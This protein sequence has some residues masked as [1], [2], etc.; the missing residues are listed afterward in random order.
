MDDFGP[1]TREILQIQI[2]PDATVCIH[3]I[4]HDLTKAEANK[5]ANVIM[6][7]AEPPDPLVGDLPGG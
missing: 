3:P 7:M 2:R 5:L 1:L 4:P 6:A